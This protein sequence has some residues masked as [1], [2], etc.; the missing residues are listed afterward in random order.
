MSDS[1]D[2]RRQELRARIAR[3]R[4][5]IDGRLRETARP[6]ARL[7]RPS[8]LLAWAGKLAFG[9]ALGWLSE[10]RA[11]FK[12]TLLRAWSLCRRAWRKRRKPATEAP[13]S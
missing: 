13:T 8:A 6:A 12:P 4:R 7:G 1:L 2:Q 9:T 5:R 3:L 11:D 10:H